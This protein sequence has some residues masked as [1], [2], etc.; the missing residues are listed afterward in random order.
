MVGVIGANGV[1]A[2][3]RLCT[4]IEEKLTQMGAYRDAHH[5][6]MLIFQATQAPSRSLYLEGRGPSFIDDY[7][8][9][10]RKMKT[11]GCDEICMCCNTAHYAIDQISNAVDVAFT[12]IITLTVS[13]LPDGGGYG[14]MCSDGCRKFGI[15]DMRI[16]HLEKN[17]R[18]IYP[19]EDYQKKVTRGICNAKNSNRFLPPDNEESPQNCFISACRNLISL[20]AKTII[21]GCTDIN[22]VFD[23]KIFKQTFPNIGY[24]D[25]LQCMA[26]YI[27]EKHIATSP[28]WSNNEIHE[29][30]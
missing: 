27:V 10:G 20:G 24:V 22:A 19:D 17:G 21:S 12:D 3:N 7:I 29:R 16:K 6:E 18:I 13:A 30:Q 15:Y 9:I 8:N 28:Y 26:D 5:P 1:A 11:F 25:S 23:S 2:T 4:L 14:I